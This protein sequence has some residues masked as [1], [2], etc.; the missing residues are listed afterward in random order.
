MTDQGWPGW[1]PPAQPG[2]TLTPVDMAAIRNWLEENP[3]A[4]S[5]RQMQGWVGFA[6]KTS[7]VAGS[8][9]RN[10][11]T[12]GDCA[13]TTGPQLTGLSDGQYLILF[14]ASIT[15]PAD[16]GGQGWMGVDVDGTDPDEPT[17]TITHNLAFVPGTGAHVHTLGGTHDHVENLD[18]SYTQNAT[19]ATANTGNTGSAGDSTVL[20]YGINLMTQIV[21]TLTGSPAGGHTLTAKYSRA[22]SGDATFESRFLTA[23]KFDNP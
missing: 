9:T 2:T 21:K 5:I 18:G 6:P 16:A 14:G 23:I 10:S 8:S 4:F 13:D 1:Q 17:E 22:G 15:P 19:T 12:Y 7:V 3:P 20:A 11:R